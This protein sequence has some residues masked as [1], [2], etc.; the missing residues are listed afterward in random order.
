M[1]YN[2]NDHFFYL[3]TNTN[4]IIMNNEIAII[5]TLIKAGIPLKTGEI[6]EILNI[7]KKDVDKAI[8]DLKK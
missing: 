4:S 5:E 6:S 1:G 3:Y 7:N 8:K 2:V